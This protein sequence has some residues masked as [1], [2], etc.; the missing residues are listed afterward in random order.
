[1]RNLLDEARER[2]V[3]ETEAQ[4]KVRRAETIHGKKKAAHLDDKSTP[5]SSSSSTPTYHISVRTSD[6]A[7]NLTSI[8]C[9][10][11]R[12]GGRGWKS[13]KIR[14][15]RQRNKEDPWAFKRGQ[16]DVFL[17]DDDLGVAFTGEESGGAWSDNWKSA[18][19]LL[20]DVETLDIWTDNVG[21]SAEW[22]MSSLQVVDWSKN[23]AFVFVN[24]QWLGGRFE[25]GGSE[26]NCVSLTK[27]LTLSRPNETKLSVHATAPPVFL[28]HLDSREF[29]RMPILKQKVLKSQQVYDM[30]LSNLRPSHVLP[31]LVDGGV[32]DEE[33]STRVLENCTTFP[34]NSN[35]ILIYELLKKDGAAFDCFLDSLRNNPTD[36]YRGLVNC[37]EGESDRRRR[38]SLAS[39][40]A[41]IRS[42]T[43]L[44]PPTPASGTR[45]STSSVMTTSFEFVPPQN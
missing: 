32:L 24:T 36:F 14:L 27:V 16:T 15:P 17:F 45:N 8:T 12:I 38:T 20:G 3:K 44:V 18:E 43:P 42:S 23:K 26:D 2:I 28:H 21:E 37:M 5:S 10:Y 34:I 22:E 39:F 41:S 30:V 13:G 31:D 40:S 4:C 11:L 29:F 25:K 1:M 33:E 35:S 19:G 9:V 6:D 7:L